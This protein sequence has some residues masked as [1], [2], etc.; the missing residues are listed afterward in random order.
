MSDLAEPQPPYGPG[1]LCEDCGHFAG[2][3]SNLV[4]HFPPES[5][6]S[7]QPCDCAGMLWGDLRWEMD[8]RTGAI[9]SVSG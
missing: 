6:R 7:R 3:H 2:R 1:A 5:R 9:R 8:S 4:C